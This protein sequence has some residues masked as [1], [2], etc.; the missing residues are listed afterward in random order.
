MN[1]FVASIAFATTFLIYNIHFPNLYAFA[2]EITH[3]DNYQRILS[4]LEI[5]HQLTASIAGVI[6][7]LLLNGLDINQFPLF[8]EMIPWQISI[9][10]WSLH[11]I[12][13]V[14]GITYVLALML[15]SFIRYQS[16]AEKSIDRQSIWIRLRQGLDYLREHRTMLLFGTLSYAVFVSVL[17][18]LYFL[19]PRYTEIVLGADVGAFAMFRGIFSIG[20]VLSGVFVSRLFRG[21]SPALAV[22]VLGA[23]GALFYGVSLFNTS[24]LVFY[25][26]GL[27]L[28]L[29]N[30]GT[31]IMRSVYVFDR[32]PNGV[33]GRVTSIFNLYHLVFRTLFSLL[34]ALPFFS[35]GNHVLWAMAGLGLF[36]AV[37]MVA[38]LFYL[39]AINKS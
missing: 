3:K 14:D 16:V 20:A 35:E 13:L 15:V 37:S 32:V 22:I 36:V 7:A 25:L 10:P 19:L 27:V 9:Q 4:Y 18:N 39:P 34:F 24:L 26:T 1:I 21:A 17:V 23:M 28:G 11:Q 2:Q 5:Q 38:L 8:G 29:S 31:R 30:A 6:A 12:F 33:M